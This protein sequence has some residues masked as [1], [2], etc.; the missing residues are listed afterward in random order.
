M[1]ERPPYLEHQI[2]G[3]FARPTARYRPHCVWINGFVARGLPVAAGLATL[4]K[5]WQS[6]PTPALPLEFPMKWP[7]SDADRITR[8]ATANI[9]VAA[10]VMGV[11]Y[12]AYLASGSVA[13]YSDA[14]ESIINVVTAA[15]ALAAVRISSKPADA[16]HQFGHHKAEFFAA[17]FEGA[18]IIV[19]ALLI[20]GKAYEAITTMTTLTSPG[21]GIAINAG[22]AA[23]NA[24]WAALLINRGSI[25]RSPALTADGR[26]LVTDV[27][28]SAGVIVGLGLAVATGWHI[29]DPILAACIAAHI[30]WSG[31][32]LT[33]GS[34]SSLLDQAASPEI[35]QRISSIIEANGG[36]AL[37]AHDIR[38]RQAG[39]ALFIEFHLVVPGAMTVDDAHAICDRL[40]TAIEL[41]IEGSEVVIHVEP[42]HKAKLQDGGA[43]PIDAR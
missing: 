23:I 12:V 34:M 40:E 1:R 16:D 28:T 29:L 13:L 8:L 41:E 10:A 6:L 18:M 43:V 7:L 27:V 19:A 15:A 2:R 20:L 24:A 32:K 9:A 5:L 11:K 36:G 38:T 17:I 26:H 31:Y 39:R 30:L 35:A 3:S 42:D 25:W 33:I 37:E 14:L 22:A 4:C 21:L